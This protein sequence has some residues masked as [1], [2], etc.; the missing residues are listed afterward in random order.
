MGALFRA[1]WRMQESRC[2]FLLGGGEP[3]VAATRRSARRDSVAGLRPLGAR[4]LEPGVAKRESLARP[5]VADIFRRGC[6]RIWG[7]GAA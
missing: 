5:R 4:E 3:R 7:R 2:Q 1:R 6:D